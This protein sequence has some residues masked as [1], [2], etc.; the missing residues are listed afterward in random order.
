MTSE[1]RVQ[2]CL[3]EKEFGAVNLS[4]IFI[5]IHFDSDCDKKERFTFH[6]QSHPI[7]FL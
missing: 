2:F 3:R 6:K 5:S 7:I 1:L 4:L